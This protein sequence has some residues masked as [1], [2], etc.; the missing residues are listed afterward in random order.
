MK[1]CL[2]LLLIGIASGALLFS[3]SQ[4]ESV[5]SS[6]TLSGSSGYITLPSASIATSYQSPALVTGYSAIYDLSRGFAHIPF[7]QLA[8][9]NRFE[10]SLAADITDGN[11]DGL[12]QA[13]WRFFQKENTAIAVGAVGQWHQIGETNSWGAQVYGVSTFNSTFINWPSKTSLLI[14]YTF[15]EVMNSNIDFGM[16]FEAPLWQKVFKG[17]VN[18]LIDFGNVS[19]STHPSAGNP[20]DRGMLNIGA[21]LLPITILPSTYLSADIRLID[22]FD[23]SGR[24]ISTALSIS[25]KP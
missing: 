5:E 13:K 4:G 16:G 12:L 1:R 25:I 17:N 14:G 15:S 10:T 11:V 9:K 22:I 24:A 18:F 19:Y 21:R 3:Q 7:V 2:I 6:F 20:T 23:H 8:L